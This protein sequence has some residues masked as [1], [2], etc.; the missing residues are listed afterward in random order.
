MATVSV[1]KTA[2]RIWLR[3]LYIALEEE[4]YDFDF[5]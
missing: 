5:A 4:L 3:V 2:H 1:Y